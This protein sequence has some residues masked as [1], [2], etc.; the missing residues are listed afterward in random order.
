LTLLQQRQRVATTWSDDYSLL[1]QLQSSDQVRNYAEALRDIDTAIADAPW[2][3]YF[4]TQRRNIEAKMSGAKPATVILDFAQQLRDAAEY[5]VRTGDD[6]LALKRY[7]LAFTT[8]SLV[9]PLDADTKFELQ[10]IVRNL[11]AF[12]S[13]N[14]NNADAVLFWQSLSHDPQLNSDQQQVAAQ[15]AARLSH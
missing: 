11:S 13:T 3:L 5:E 12:L 8:L 2:Q 7:M 6:G 15:E 9:Q 1:A 14:Y 4:Y 10:T